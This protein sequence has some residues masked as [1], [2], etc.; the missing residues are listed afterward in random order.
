MLDFSFMNESGKKDDYLPDLHKK[1]G[2][3]L[4]PAMA[5]ALSPRARGIHRPPDR[6]A[7]L[8]RFIPARAGDTAVAEASS[9]VI[10]GSSPRARGIRQSL[11]EDFRFRRL[12]PAYTGDTI[13]TSR[14]EDHL[15]G[16]PRSRGGYI[17]GP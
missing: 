15:T 12:I 4:I 1:T 7:L 13:T 9:N 2:I 10:R 3:N 14:W 16:H 5:M 11:Y 17:G 6:A 8:A